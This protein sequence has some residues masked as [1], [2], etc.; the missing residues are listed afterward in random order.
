M[1]SDRK[2]PLQKNKKKLSEN[3]FSAQF[4]RALVPSN[5]FKRFVKE[6]RMRFLEA[7]A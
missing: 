3:H 5:M 7:G 4:L 1:P 6:L 2:L